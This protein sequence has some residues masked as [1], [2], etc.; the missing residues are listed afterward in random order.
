MVIAISDS[1][2]GLIG[3]AQKVWKRIT[4]IT[5]QYPALEAGETVTIVYGDTAEG[6][7]SVGIK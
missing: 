3:K 7:P 5:V 6:S 1:G 2:A 4:R